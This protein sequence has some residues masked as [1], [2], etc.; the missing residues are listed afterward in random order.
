M[1]GWRS[2]EASS[3][4]GAVGVPWRQRV[5]LLAGEYG[6][7]AA[8]GVVCGMIPAL[9]AIQPAARALGAQ[10]PWAA[11]ATVAAGLVVCL[12]VCVWGAARAAAGRFDP[13]AL[14]EL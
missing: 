9:V 7:L 14:R 5:R 11:M 3:R 8:A 10:L 13:A 6:V 12:A 4:C 2:G 1:R